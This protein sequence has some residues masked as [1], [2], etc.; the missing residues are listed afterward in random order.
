[1][2]KEVPLRKGIYLFVKSDATLERNA[3]FSYFRGLSGS[4]WAPG[5][6][7]SSKKSGNVLSNHVFYDRLSMSPSPLSYGIAFFSENDPKVV[8]P[9]ESGEGEVTNHCIF[10][11]RNELRAAQIRSGDLKSIVFYRGNERS[12]SPLRSQMTLSDSK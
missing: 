11:R 9:F 7:P 5:G 4:I 8:I 2:Q 12:P 6:P 3:R 10:T 1:M